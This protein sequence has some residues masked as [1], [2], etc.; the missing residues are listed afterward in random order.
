MTDINQFYQPMLGFIQRRVHSLE[1]AEDLTQEVF[2]R[3]FHSNWTQINHLKGW[4]FKIARN[5]IIDYYRSKSPKY[6]DSDIESLLYPEGEV[7]GLLEMAECVRPF[8]QTLEKPLC[9]L[10]TQ[11]DLEGVSQKQLA[12]ELGI[13]YSALKSQ[14]QRARKKLIPI[15]ESCCQGETRACEMKDCGCHEAQGF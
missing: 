2:L 8:I 15:V 1:D 9:D 12:Q 5:L 3:A 13:S 7:D 4:L 10:L 6:S 11:V 14:V